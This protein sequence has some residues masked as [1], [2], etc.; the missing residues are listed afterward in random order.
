ML[1]LYTHSISPL[2]L[3][4]D[5]HPS[6]R[7]AVL[8]ITA[9]PKMAQAVRDFLHQLDDHLTPVWITSVDKACQRLEWEHPKMAILDTADTYDTTEAVDALHHIFPELELLFLGGLPNGTGT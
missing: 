1:P 3:S 4:I 5:V 7:Q 8:I 2:I 9:S 6:D